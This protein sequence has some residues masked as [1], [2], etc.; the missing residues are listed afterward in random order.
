MTLPTQPDSVF[1]ETRFWILILLSI[2]LPSCTFAMGLWRREVRPGAVL[3]LGFVLVAVSTIDIA[4]LQAL[5]DTARHTPSL[6]DDWLFN[7]EVSTALYAVPILFGGLGVNVISHVLI[8]HLDR[9]SAGKDRTIETPAECLR[10]HR[11]DTS[12]CHK[13]DEGMLNQ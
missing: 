1:V 12:C 5:A 7:S 13:Y 8:S 3:T 2:L 10:R 6:A 11:D 4:L 9:V